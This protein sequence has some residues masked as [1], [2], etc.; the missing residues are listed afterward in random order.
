MNAYANRL[1]AVMVVC[2][3]AAVIAPDSEHARRYIRVV[4][5]LTV[6]L[7]MLSPLSRLLEAS[8]GITEKVTAFFTA[9]QTIP[10]EETEAG[11][12]GLM[13]YVAER[14]GVSDLSVT[15]RTDGTDM[16]I[17][18][19]RFYIPDCPYS[20]RAAIESDLN[21]QLAFPVE[22]FANREG[23]VQKNHETETG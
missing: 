1:I 11:A 12:V 3:I 19:I 21:G 9:D 5:A 6:L 16:E 2:Q 18:G 4:C 17:I 14:Y 15:I 7:T 10:Y 13:Q 23:D 22:V 20:T 8:D